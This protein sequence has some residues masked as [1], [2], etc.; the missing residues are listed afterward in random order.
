METKNKQKN[1]RLTLHTYREGGSMICDEQK[2][3]FESVP[4][5]DEIE[6]IVATYKRVKNYKGLVFY[7]ISGRIKGGEE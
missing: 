4:T 7:N 6:K 2:I 3:D 5:S 1:V